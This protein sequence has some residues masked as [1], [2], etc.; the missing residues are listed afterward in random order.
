MRTTGPR[1][2]DPIESHLADLTA[3][4]HGPAGAKGRMVAELRE[5]LLDAA[6]AMSAEPGS[7]RDAARRAVREFGTVAELAPSFQHELTMA[8]ARRTARTV[9]LIVPGPVLCW[10]LVALSAG[11]AVHRLP[12]PVQLWI[13][14][15][16]GTA[17]LTALLA[18]VLLAATGSLAR[19][20]PTP[21]RLPLV[22]A[23]T[24][25][26]AAAALALS[27]LTLTV[28][29]VLAANWP[30]SAAACV[31][32]IALHT[33]LAASARACRECARLPATGP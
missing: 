25:T 11:T 28:A 13:A 12:G 4:L 33:R 32:T 23:W 29:S 3:A 26:T 30:L 22:V 18:G 5:G 27:A 9:L 8:Q 16:G 15:L 31:V 19:L 17:A 6:R 21:Q 24:G 10:Y 7:D 20:L 1:T 2:D 14:H